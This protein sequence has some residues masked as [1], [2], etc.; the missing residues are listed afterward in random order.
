M[1]RIDT[2]VVGGGMAG[3]TATAYLAKA[4]KSVTLFERIDYFGGL[5]NS[6]SRDGFTFDGGLRS[7]ENS[8]IVFPMLKQLGIELEF[9]KSPVSLILGNQ[10][11]NLKGTGSIDA[12]Q[13]F[14]EAEFPEDRVSIRKIIRE[15]KKVTRYMDVLYGIDNPLFMDIDKN[16]GYL[17]REL[18]PWLIKFLLTIRKIEKLNV[19]VYPFLGRFTQNQE[20]LDSIAQHFFRETP[21]S[22]ALS[23]FSL[24]NDYHYPV[25]AT[26]MLPKKLQ[27]FAEER[28]AVL[29]ADTSIVKIDPEEKWVID[30]QGKK[31][32]YNQLIWACDLKTLYRII[33]TDALKN[34]ALK[35]QVRLRRSQLEGL[36]GAESVFTSYFAVGVKPAY[37]GSIASGHSFYT[38]VKDGLS[39]VLPPGDDKDSIRN[40]LA[41]LVRN[42]TLEISIPALRD[43]SLSPPN[44]T[45]IEVSLL[46]DYELA[47]KMESQGWLEESKAF[48][49]ELILREL[50]KLYPEMKDKV[51]FRFSSTPLTIERYTG[52]S[53]GAIVGW[54]FANPEIPVVHRFRDVAKSVLTP[55]PDIYQAGQWTYSPAG[56]PISILTGKLAANK[57]L[58]RK[59]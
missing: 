7:I 16:P 26:E 4:G 27:Q 37:F 46:F 5:V 11:L 41:N 31:Y 21:S 1:N 55:I 58:K 14:L 25:G 44:G 13:I 10:V 47:K 18:L 19:P 28:G 33:D 17:F 40:Y 36:S 29:Q 38:P 48:M 54:S 59:R 15:I 22:F 35:D 49:E 42:N 2:I 3:L 20:L 6:F 9:V 57:V 12:Y 53:G 43:P 50:E 32:F 30:H 52:N 45:G 34:E 23:Y 24:Y 8:G 56:V 39:S 51:L